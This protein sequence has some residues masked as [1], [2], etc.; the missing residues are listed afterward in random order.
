MLCLLNLFVI[1]VNHT[2]QLHEAFNLIGNE[3]HIFLAKYIT[4]DTAFFLDLL[5]V[6]V[7]TYLI[8][9]QECQIYTAGHTYSTQCGINSSHPIITGNKAS[10]GKKQIKQADGFCDLWVPCRNGPI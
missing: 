3:Y 6:N 4:V 9:M 1:A 10:I 2:A 5:S 8:C 7:G